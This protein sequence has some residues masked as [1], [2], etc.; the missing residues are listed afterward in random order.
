MRNR[1]PIERTCVVLALAAL[2]CGSVYLALGQID[3]P[4]RALG[5]D[6]WNVPAQLREVA[7]TD[8]NVRAARAEQDDM[9]LIVQRRATILRDVLDA[10]LSVHEGLTQ[11][12][13]LYEESPQL[14]QRLRAFYHDVQPEQ[15]LLTHYREHLEEAMRLHPMA[16]AWIRPQFD[17]LF[18]PMTMP[19]SSKGT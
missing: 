12:Q 9:V 16:I 2:L 13:H 3:A 7:Q 11:L 17:E 6:V 4:A 8:R 15:I 18:P 14:Q 1:L 19:M 10:R 5:L